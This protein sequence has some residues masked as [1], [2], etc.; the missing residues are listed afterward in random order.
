MKKG[1]WGKVNHSLNE[2]KRQ[3]RKVKR[4]G[5]GK[6]VEIENKGGRGESQQV[7]G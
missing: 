4:N 3:M 1:G 5:E 6:R 2:K 7:L